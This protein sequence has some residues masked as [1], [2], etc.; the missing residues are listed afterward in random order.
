[1]NFLKAAYEEGVKAAKQQ[2]APVRAPAAPKAPSNGLRA[3]NQA[4]QPAAGQSPI[5]AANM[6]RSTPNPAQ[7]LAAA[8]LVTT[9]A[10]RG[11]GTNM[12]IGG[13]V[14][15]VGASG[16]VG[17]VQPAGN[18]M[19]NA[20]S[21][22][23]V[24]AAASNPGGTRASPAT[25]MAGKQKVGEFNMGMHPDPATKPDK[26]PKPDNGRRMYGTQFSDALRPLRDVD[27]AFNDLSVPKNTDVLNN[28]GQAE[29]G[30]P[31]G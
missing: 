27:A 26:G 4:P 28:M 23:A 12:P 22:Q 15:P 20:N 21:P 7:E 25:A 18:T 3:P 13:T 11:N 8:N 10:G 9:A 24:G 19:M 14:A 30:A 29:F 31:R 16:Q 1:M 17:T 6:A 2:F 5:S